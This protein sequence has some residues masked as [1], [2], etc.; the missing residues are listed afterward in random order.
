MG[1]RIHLL[2]GKKFKTDERIRFPGGFVDPTDESL[3]MAAKREIMEEA[4]GIATEGPMIYV[5]STLVNDWR[6]RG[7][8]RIMTSL[9]HTEYTWGH[10]KA[11]DD[12]AEV[13]WHPFDPKT[14][15]KIEPC[16]QP[17]YDMLKKYM[18]ETYLRNLK[19]QEF[20]DANLGW[21]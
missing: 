20:V 13:A 21:K 11:G 16:H 14:R 18:K 3:E 2:L 5:G 7:Q 6:Y 17:L 12:L 9:F 8:D 19:L 10:T 15:D 1:N 4:P